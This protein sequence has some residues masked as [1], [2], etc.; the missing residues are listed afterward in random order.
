MIWIAPHLQEAGER[1]DA[2]TIR[3]QDKLPLS[4]HLHFG[5]PVIW[6]ALHH[7]MHDLASGTIA[8]YVVVK[9]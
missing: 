9:A 1:K 6:Q 7:V 4:L 3:C 2:I 8:I 5:S